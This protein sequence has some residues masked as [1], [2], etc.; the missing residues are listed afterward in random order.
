MERVEGFL[1]WESVTGIKPG[2]QTTET[3]FPG[4]Q[5]NYGNQ[6]PTWP[7]GD[8]TPENTP[9]KRNGPRFQSPWV[10]GRIIAQ[11]ANGSSIAA[12]VCPFPNGDAVYVYYQDLDLHLREKIWSPDEQ[13]WVTGEH[14]LTFDDV[15]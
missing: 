6:S 13:A 14:V 15:A 10:K 11:A 3:T 5:V 1:S 2:R 7:W 8:R 9:S 4:S 12:V